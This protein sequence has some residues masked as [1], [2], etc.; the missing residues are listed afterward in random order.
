MLRLGRRRRS[1][2][3][4]PPEH[5]GPVGTEARA[6]KEVELNA[7]DF[8]YPPNGFL[9]RMEHTMLYSMIKESEIFP[10]DVVVSAIQEEN[11]EPYLYAR[12]HR[13]SNTAEAGVSYA[14]LTAVLARSAEQWPGDSEVPR[15][16]C[17]EVI[18]CVI[19]YAEKNGLDRKTETD[20][21]IRPMIRLAERK[22]SQTS[23]A[24]ILPAYTGLALSM[25]TGNPVPMLLSSVAMNVATARMVANDASN[26]E[27]LSSYMKSSNR[28]A[29]VEKASLLD[30][31]HEDSDGDGEH[32]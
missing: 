16:L 7:K 31:C 3:R 28:M 15:V 20:E 12:P 19:R 14:Q 2:T 4:T 30:E 23:L 5:G 9:T 1:D 21:L 18:R 11:F 25:V 29:D 26:H 10:P 8:K 13:S 27:N 22:N 32:P 6:A 17:K 24:V